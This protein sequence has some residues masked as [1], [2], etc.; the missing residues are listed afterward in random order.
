MAGLTGIGAPL[1]AL[2]EQDTFRQ[3]QRLASDRNLK[4]VE[5]ARMIVTAE[6]GFE[7]Q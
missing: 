5:V 7:P 6:E 3:L 1:C 2:D 4:L